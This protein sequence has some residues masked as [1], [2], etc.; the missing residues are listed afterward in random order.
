M[1]LDVTVLRKH[2]FRTLLALYLLVHFVQLIPWGAELFSNAGVIP[3]AKFSPLAS[4]FP[5]LFTVWDSPL[6]VT[7]V[8]VA[9]SILCVL[10]LLGCDDRLVAIILWYFWACLY[11]RNPLISNPALPFVGWLLLAHACIPGSKSADHRSTT[12]SIRFAAW[13]VLSA[14]YSYSGYTKLM[15]PSWLD[16]SAMVHVLNSPLA[17]PTWFRKTLIHFP[18][19]I[20][21]VAS[22]SVLACELFFAPLCIIRRFRLFLWSFMLSVHVGLIVLLDFADLSIGMILFHLFTAPVLSKGESRQ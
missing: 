8:L 1:P 21:G 5:N 3:E 4:L 6:V 14:A 19:L 11:G 20:L 18:F 15:S 13:I 12:H 16:G 9:S 22:W 17:R 10:L 2:A 7:T